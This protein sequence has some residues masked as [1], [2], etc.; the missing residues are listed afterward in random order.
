MIPGVW[1][2][3]MST[4]AGKVNKKMTTQMLRNGDIAVKIVPPV[5]VPVKSRILVPS[6]TALKQQPP[7]LPKPLGSPVGFYCSTGTGLRLY[8]L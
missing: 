5:R 3:S 7:I 2:D 4:A 8:F 1:A 6:K